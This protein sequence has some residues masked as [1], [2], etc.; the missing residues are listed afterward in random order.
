MKK[1]NSF[2][3]LFFLSLKKINFFS[4]KNHSNDFFKLFFLVNFIFFVFFLNKIYIYFIFFIIFLACFLF[5]LK[6]A[7]YL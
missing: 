6:K 5:I 1:K 3:A 4:K 2:K 7:I